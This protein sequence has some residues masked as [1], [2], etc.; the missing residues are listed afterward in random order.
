MIRKKDLLDAVD[1]LTIQLARQG[2]R[3]H[4]LEDQVFGSWEKARKITEKKKAKEEKKL[5]KAVKE[6]TK[7]APKRGRGRPRKNAYTNCGAILKGQR[8]RKLLVVIL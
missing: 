2:E 1:C 5:K 7:D 6:V 4:N 3:I 8:K